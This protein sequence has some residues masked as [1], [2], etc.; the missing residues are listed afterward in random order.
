MTNRAFEEL[1]RRCQALRRKRFLKWALLIVFLLVAVGTIVLMWYMPDKK[2]VSSKVSQP[3]QET[4]LHHDINQSKN[5]AT[6]DQAIVLNSPDI[7][8][9][10]SDTKPEKKRAT[11]TKPAKIAPAK[12][13]KIEP[14]REPKKVTPKE[15]KPTIKIFV[16]SVGNETS[17]LE[18]NRKGEDFDSSLKLSQFYLKAHKYEKAIQYSKRANHFNPSSAK[19]WLI[20]AKAKIKQNKRSEAIKA[21]ETYLSYFSS[22]DASNLLISIKGKQ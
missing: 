10:L 19:P 2:V 4:R 16:K 13:K 5:I 22:D 20:Y 1:E 3:L 14:V 15:E 6:Q 7:V 9:K 12:V 8:P 17:L 11:V 18:S 21:L